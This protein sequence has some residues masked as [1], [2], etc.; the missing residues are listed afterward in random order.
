MEESESSL[1]EWRSGRI[2]KFIANDND[3]SVLHRWS[4]FPLRIA[5]DLFRFCA[6]AG[7]GPGQH[8]QIGFGAGDVVV[9]DA[10]AGGDDRS[11]AGELDEFADPVRRTDARIWPSLAIDARPGVRRGCLG[12]APNDG[13]AST[14]FANQ[15]GTAAG[16][17]HDACQR[18]DVFVDVGEEARIEREK[19][20]WL[21]KNAGN[22][23][24]RKGDGAD[25]EGWFEAHHLIEIEFP[26]VADLRA[27][28]CV[29][30]V[31]APFGDA[32]QFSACAESEEDGGDARREGDDSHWFVDCHPK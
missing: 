21:L 13:K 18:A 16:A 30:D 5:Q 4:V 12:L 25:Q 22:S 28:A 10:L 8:D 14:N 1:Q 24:F 26:T 19:L 2:E 15:V 31:F 17:S 27:R 11:A 6:V 7:S 9:G 20:D 29:G 3:A 23:F 32:D